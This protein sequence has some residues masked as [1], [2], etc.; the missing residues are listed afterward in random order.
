M[1]KKYLTDNNGL[2]SCPSSLFTEPE[3]ACF[4]LITCLCLMFRGMWGD[5]VSFLITGRSPGRKRWKERLWTKEEG[6]PNTDSTKTAVVGHGSEQKDS[7][8]KKE[9]W[10]SE[11]RFPQREEKIPQ[12]NLHTWKTCSG[13]FNECDECQRPH[14]FPQTVTLQRVLD[15]RMR[16]ERVFH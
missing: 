15:L 11:R 12:R 6:K 8:T 3:K 7:R 13:T 2:E 14:T 16:F 9:R 4:K 1:G 5:F 10:E